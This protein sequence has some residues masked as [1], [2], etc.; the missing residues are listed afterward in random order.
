MSEK[1]DD[2]AKD[3]ASEVDHPD[4]VGDIFLWVTYNSA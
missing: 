3:D 2:S 4:E 1:F